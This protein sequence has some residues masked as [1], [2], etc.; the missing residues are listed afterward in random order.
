MKR[1]RILE[2]HFHARYESF[3]RIK[4]WFFIRWVCLIQMGQSKFCALRSKQMAD[5]E[6]ILLIGP[7]GTQANNSRELVDICR[8]IRPPAEADVSAAALGG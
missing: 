3:R 1:P 4:W 6:W 5:N 7:L 2:I 8:E